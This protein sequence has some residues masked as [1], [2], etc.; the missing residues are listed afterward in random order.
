MSKDLWEK[1]NGYLCAV[2]AECTGYAHNCHHKSALNIASLDIPE[3]G[4][5]SQWS[6]LGHMWLINVNS[7]AL[8]RSGMLCGW[9]GSFMY[10]GVHGLYL[11]PGG[12]QG[13]QGVELLASVSLS[14]CVTLRVTLPWTSIPLRES[15]NIPSDFILQKTETP[16]AW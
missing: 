3:N 13:H 10:S 2:I 6:F 4:S 9:M 7:L 16:L 14:T 8:C 5:H 12:N 15:R 1:W 11:S